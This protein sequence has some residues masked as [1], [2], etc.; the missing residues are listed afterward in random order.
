MIS[1]DIFI[2]RHILFL[3]KYIILTIV[4]FFFSEIKIFPLIL[5]SNFKNLSF[6]YPTFETYCAF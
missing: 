2:S 1:N 6:F 3:L 4:T 5:N